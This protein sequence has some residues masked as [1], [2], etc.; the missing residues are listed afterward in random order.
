MIPFAII[1]IDATDRNRSTVRAHPRSWRRGGRR[2]VGGR[3]SGRRRRQHVHAAEFAEGDAVFEHERVVR[4]GPLVAHQR[5]Y[6]PLVAHAHGAHHLVDALVL[7]PR[8]QAARADGVAHGAPILHTGKERRR[9]G[10]NE[11]C[12][13]KSST[14]NEV[15]FA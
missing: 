11:A 6:R 12:T 1:Q 4:V 13:R 8:R 3:A 7:F 9:V 5:K 14:R 2:L 10:A 15:V